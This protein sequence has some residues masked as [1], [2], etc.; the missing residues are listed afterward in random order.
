MFKFL[1]YNVA[2]FSENTLA[3]FTMFPK[4]G[5]SISRQNLNKT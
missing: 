1:P 5:S 4:K 3:L 2:L